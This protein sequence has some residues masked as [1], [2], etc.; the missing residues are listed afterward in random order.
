MVVALRSALLDSGAGG[1]TARGRGRA[2]S[3]QGLAPASLT[4]GRGRAPALRVLA[5]TASPIG[6][7]APG[8]A[9]SPNGPR[10]W[11]GTA[12]GSGAGAPE[13]EG[14]IEGAGLWRATLFVGCGI[15]TESDPWAEYAESVL[16]LAP[17]LTAL[18]GA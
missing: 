10:A 2:L 6:P 1:E 13:S 8:G 4:R 18:G 17:M 7:R 15:V 16:K 5:G 12:P 14:A 9:A 3:E 11:D